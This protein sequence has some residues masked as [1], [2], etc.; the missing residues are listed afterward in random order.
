MCD[1]K[2]PRK[3]FG[4]KREK[5]RAVCRKVKRGKKLITGKLI[6]IYKNI[7]GDFFLACLLFLFN[8]HSYC[9]YRESVVGIVT[10]LTGW[11]VRDSNSGMGRK[12]SSQKHPCQF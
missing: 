12:N 7:Y 8:A 6:S 2:V 10:K 3:A 4:Q 11:E 5:I 9:G 1:G